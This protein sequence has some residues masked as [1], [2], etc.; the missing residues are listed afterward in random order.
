MA[1][2]RVLKKLFLMSALVSALLLAAP[3]QADPRYLGEYHEGGHRGGWEHGGGRYD[4]HWRHGGYGYG[5]HWRGRGW[6]YAPRHYY[7]P[8]R[9]YYGPPR[10]YGPRY[11]RHYRGCGHE[12]YYH[13]GLVEFL[14]DYSRYDD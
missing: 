5:D 2:G 8:P 7:A 3:V 11:H 6:G 4:R 12:G 10:Y 9:Y 13:G 1:T 14:V